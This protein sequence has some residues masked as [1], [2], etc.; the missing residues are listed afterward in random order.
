MENCYNWQNQELS[1]V[2]VLHIRFVW[3]SVR[4]GNVV[5]V[6]DFHTPYI[7]SKLYIFPWFFFRDFQY[8]NRTIEYP[9]G[10]EYPWGSLSPTPGCMQHHP[11]S[12]PCV[13]EHCPNTHRTLTA[14]GC[15][16]C[17]GQPVPWPPPSGA[18]PFP[19]PPL[20]LP[21]HS[22]M[23][24]LWAISVT[25][26][27]A[28]HCEELQ[29][30]WGLNLLCSGLS[31]PRHLSHSSYIL[32]SRPFTIFAAP[33]FSSFTFFLHCSSQNCTSAEQ[34]PPLAQWQCWAWC[35]PGY[36]WP[37]WLQ[38]TLLTHVLLAINQNPQIPSCGDPFRTSCGWRLHSPLI[39]QDLFAKPV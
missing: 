31:K 11:K 32:S 20:S 28:Q 10:G 5:C 12:K 3:W 23:R 6:Y 22:S 29:L 21:W 27:R 1:A 2:Q 15:A 9:W 17:P 25:E 36:S 38:G 37:F 8:R 35:T 33:L 18:D 4:Q 19:N 13:W 30:P 34:T 14:Q 26:S 24:F 7:L 39:C 16:H